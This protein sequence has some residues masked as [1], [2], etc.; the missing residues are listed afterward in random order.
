MLVVTIAASTEDAVAGF[1]EQ[2]NW[3]FR[4]PS[5]LQT[6]LNREALRNQLNAGTPASAGP[7]AIGLGVPEAAGTTMV[8]STTGTTNYN[9]TL[10]GDNNEVTVDG[11]LNLNTNQNSEGRT[12]EVR[13]EKKV[14]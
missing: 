13:N 2:Q 12:S 1:R 9:V 10:T 8:N 4:S 7:T 6:N 5:E 3:P 11:Y 14:K